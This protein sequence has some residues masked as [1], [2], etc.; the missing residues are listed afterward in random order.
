M[1]KA[2]FL[3]FV[4]LAFMSCNSVLTFRM[5]VLRSG[6]VIVPSGNSSILF[7]DNSGLQP[8]WFGHT[9]NLNSKYAKDT[10]FNT[11]SLSDLVLKSVS[12]AVLSKGFFSAVKICDRDENEFHKNMDDKFLDANIL[13]PIQVLDLA[14]SAHVD[15]L[16][17]LD[18]MIIQS[19]S[20]DQTFDLIFKATRDVSLNTV[21][22]IFDVKVDTLLA[23]LQYND[24]LFWEKYS[25]KSLD[26]VKKELPR[27]EETL[28]E[29]AD[30]L[31]E[32]I[33]PILSPHWESVSRP[34]FSSG[35]Y[36]MLYAVD[37]VRQNDWEG[38]AV[39][40]K[41]EFNKGFGKSVYHA[42]MNMILYAEYLQDPNKA[43]VWCEK[44]DLAMR[45]HSSSVTAYDRWLLESW[46]KILRVRSAEF[47]M[48]KFLLNDPQNQENSH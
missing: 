25:T 33:S 4:V 42:A 44:A 18:R 45:D 30:V 43:L 40:W 23:Q 36:R 32:R 12:K 47:E 20:N 28:P 35:S 9:L 10:V 8:Q 24:S 1:K 15:L 37:C 31:G 27:M 29:I 39:L 26:A 46:K 34:Y 13:T 7:V 14:D 19:K 2:V 5:D 21:W 48:L 11:D 17:S 6:V 22:R 16:I 38:A 41:E 3:L